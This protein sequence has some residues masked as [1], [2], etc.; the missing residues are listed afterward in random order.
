M[1]ILEATLIRLERQLE[2]LDVILRDAKTELLD[3]RS[4]SGEWSARENLAHLA[5]HA[6]VFLDRLNRILRENRP[7]LGTYRAETDPEWTVW[8]A[9]PFI[10]ALRKL[11]DAR[12]RLLVWV[13]SLND[14]QAR[15]TGIHPT[16]GE[17][18]VPQWLEFFLLHEAHHLYVTMIRIG[19]ARGMAQSRA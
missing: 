3:V 17:M 14:D 5:R 4:T 11:R 16:F 6:E 18:S 15:R 8:S 10:E 19:E 7:H 13:R 12:R 9:L 2:A 1:A